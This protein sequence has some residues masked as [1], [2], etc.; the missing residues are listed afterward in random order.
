VGKTKGLSAIAAKL[1]VGRDTARGL[2]AGCTFPAARRAGVHVV[3]TKHLEGYRR[4]RDAL[5][6]WENEGGACR[7]QIEG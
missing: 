1:G 5:P 3:S 2:V 6:A 7:Q 4:D